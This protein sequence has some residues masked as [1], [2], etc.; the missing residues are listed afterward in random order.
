M[1]RATKL[2]AGWVLALAPLAGSGCYPSRYDSSNYDSVV[3]LSDT[4]AV[5]G[6]A[7]TFAL[8]DSVVHL[9]PPG[10][11]DE[12]TRIYDQQILDQIRTNMLANGYTEVANPTV[13]NLN[14]MTLATSSTY[15]GYYWDNWCGYYGWWYPYGCGYPG[16]WYTYEY[17][18]GSVLIG[19]QDNRAVANN[20]A[21]LIWFAG[22]SGLVGQGVTPA[23]LNAAIDQAFDQSPYIHHP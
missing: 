21:P 11:T 7:T 15:Y 16:Y 4:A 13:A 2:I 10:Q 17:T 9:V 20:K 3:T 1:H 19:M 22:L 14:L 12:L 5:F 18:V 8:A 23:R 6:T